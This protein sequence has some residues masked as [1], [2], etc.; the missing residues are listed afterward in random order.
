MNQDKLDQIK[1]RAEKC[2]FLKLDNMPD[3]VKQIIEVDLP[4]L[5]GECQDFL[6]C[7]EECSLSPHYRFRR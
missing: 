6:D 7:E 5:I 4:E 1:L 3:L 2:E